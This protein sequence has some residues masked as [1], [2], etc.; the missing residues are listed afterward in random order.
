MN[1]YPPIAIVFAASLVCFSQ[2]AAQRYVIGVDIVGSNSKCP[3][4]PLFIG[5]VRKISPAAQQEFSLAIDYWP[6]MEHPY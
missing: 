3:G 1:R 2:N 5:S 6:L 4:S